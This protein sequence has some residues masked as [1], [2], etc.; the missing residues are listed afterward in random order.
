MNRLLKDN[1]FHYFDLKVSNSAFKVN[2][3]AHQT[4]ISRNL[5]PGRII[6]SFREQDS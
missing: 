2:D 3:M 4:Q 5:S 1:F 6:R